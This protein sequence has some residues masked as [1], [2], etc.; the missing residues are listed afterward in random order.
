MWFEILDLEQHVFDYTLCQHMV[1]LRL[2]CSTFNT[3]INCT[4][5]RHKGLQTCRI[6]GS[7]DTNRAI[8]I[9][10][11]Y[12]RIQRVTSIHFDNKKQ[13]DIAWNYMN[14]FGEISH[15]CCEG[16]GVMYKQNGMNDYF[17]KRLGYSYENT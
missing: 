13:L 14:N 11:M 12:I 2:V 4:L 15:I 7:Y 16:K 1:A 5:N 10:E 6:H 9:L 17:T 8:D 3:R